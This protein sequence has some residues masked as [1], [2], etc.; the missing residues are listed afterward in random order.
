MKTI[1][2]I[3]GR[4]FI[5]KIN[6]KKYDKPFD[7]MDDIVGIRVVC[8]YTDDIDRI[9]KLIEGEFGIIKK[10]KKIENLDTDKMGY[11]DLSYV[12]KLKDKQELNKFEI[13]VRSIMCDAA[14]IISHDL[15]YKKEPKLPEELERELN[16]VFST[17]ELTQYHCDSLKERRKEY[18][19]GLEQKAG[20]ADSA[21]FLNQ[22]INDDSLRVYT[23]K[24][25]PGLP[26]KEHIHALILR[27]LDSSKYK[28]LKDIDDAVQYSKIFVDF[29]KTQ[30]DSFKSG[31]DYITKSLGYYDEQ[32]LN[33][34]PF[35][36]KTRDAVKK[37]KDE[38]GHL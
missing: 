8:L 14:A 27:D 34:H 10:D 38:K 21:E 22:S 28:T 24:C 2:F 12:A 6:R 37:F 1:L 18:V 9:G 32:F 3:D 29:Y 11:Q 33:R 19:K 35:A 31:S 13:Q 36:Q 20:K 30:S 4:N 26:I 25:F 5:E 23:N 17:L 16:L 7:Q 15:G